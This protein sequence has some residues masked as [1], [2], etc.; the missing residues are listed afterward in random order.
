MPLLLPALSGSFN[1]GGHC[2]TCPTTG[3]GLNA[4]LRTVWV[5]LWYQ[6]ISQKCQSPT[7]V[8]LLS[9]SWQLVR[10]SSDPFR[11]PDSVQSSLISCDCF[12]A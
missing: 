2:E 5:S 11:L 10:C 4:V 7:P 3:K 1:D 8:G 12:K 6:R 9:N